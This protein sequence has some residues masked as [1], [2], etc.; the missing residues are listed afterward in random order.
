MVASYKLYWSFCLKNTFAPLA[1]SPIYTSKYIIIYSTILLYVYHRF[2]VVFVLSSSRDRHII[3]T[4]PPR[5]TRDDII[6]FALVLRKTS[7]SPDDP[8]GKS[9]VVLSYARVMRVYSAKL[10][11]NFPYS[12]IH[13]YNTRVYYYV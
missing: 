7:P 1:F 9:H 2:S 8:G 5:R 6:L 3:S 10:R 12:H 4:H 11:K 13:F